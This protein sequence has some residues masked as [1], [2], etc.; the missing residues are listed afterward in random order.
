MRV[1]EA[2][3]ALWRR[4][5]SGLSDKAALY[6]SERLSAFMASSPS[7]SVAEVREEAKEL[8][9]DALGMYGDQAATLAADFFEEVMEAEGVTVASEAYDSIDR[10]LVDSKVR[11]LAQRLTAGGHEG[12][13]TSVAD[14][15]AYYVR[16]QAYETTVRNCIGNEVRYARVPSGRE[17]CGFCFML[18]SRGFVYHSEA[19]A[20]GLSGHGMHRHCDCV[21]VPGV[22]GVTSVDGYDS[23]AMA[24]RW[25][26]C[27]KTCGSNDP[28]DV[29]RECEARDPKW[30]Y[31]GKACAVSREK[32][33]K[34][35]GKETSVAEILSNEGFNVSFIREINK[36]NQKTADA[37]LNDAIW[38]FKI[39]EEYNAK[40]VKNQ[41][42]KARGKGTSRLLISNASNHA[43]SHAMVGDV[44]RILASEEFSFVDEVLFVG[45]DGFVRR[46]FRA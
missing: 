24:E 25:E 18:S 43:D 10:G 1:S 23:E 44:E 8:I 27:R 29:I 39:P 6:V 17:T 9:E 31:T 37:Y 13:V 15:T 38:E 19:T 22:A 35:L 5:I 32:G 14:V 7:A 30:L 36:S 16:R 2:T 12:F 11:Y 42:K 46:M 21:I 3:L 45:E 40:T 20:K 41:F 28:K 33:A 4:E 26:Q 34:P